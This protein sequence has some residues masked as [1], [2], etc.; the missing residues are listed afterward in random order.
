M[1]KEGAIQSLTFIGGTSL[2]L[3][4]FFDPSVPIRAI[5]IRAIRDIES[6]CYEKYSGWFDVY[7]CAWQLADQPTDPLYLKLKLDRDC[8][9]IV[10]AS[11]HRE[12]SL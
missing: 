3:C 5:P 11:F 6:I 4:S 7:H 2:R 8:I 1:V 10:L 9:T 12:G